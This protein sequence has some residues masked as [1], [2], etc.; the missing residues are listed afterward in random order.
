MLQGWGSWNTVGE[1]QEITAN[2][3]SHDEWIA[4]RYPVVLRELSLEE[5]GGWLATIPMLGEAG[6]AA[7]GETP[8]EAVASLSQLRRDLYETVMNSGQPIPLPCDVSDEI[9]MPSGKWMMRTLPKF[10][11]ELQEAAKASGVSFNAYCTYCLGR[12]HAVSSVAAVVED[13]VR[14]G[15]VK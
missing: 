10:H 6:F 8:E 14:V 13:L 12:G 3:L 9:K 7:D 1:K 5:G 2:K 11:A 4:L 15:S